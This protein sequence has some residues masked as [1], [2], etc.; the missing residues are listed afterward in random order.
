MNKEL[1]GQRVAGVVMLGAILALWGCGEIAGS[2]AEMPPEVSEAQ[3]AS[4]WVTPEFQVHGHKS[5]QG[6]AQPEGLALTVEE[7][8]LVAT[9]EGHEDEVLAYAGPFELDLDLG[10]NK[11]TWRVEPIE[12]DATG[13]YRVEV[14]VRGAEER[15]ERFLLGGETQPTLNDD[16]WGQRHSSDESDG[17]PLPLPADQNALMVQPEPGEDTSGELPM[18]SLASDIVVEPGE[19]LLSIDVEFETWA[20]LVFPAIFEGQGFQKVGEAEVVEQTVTLGD[21]A[22]ERERFVE[23]SMATVDEM[24]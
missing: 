13:A 6:E 23:E 3:Q 14:D 8:R 16:A 10:K 11:T 2:E 1:R 12:V 9:E 21:G 20:A 24:P 19:Q 22:R 7:I 15:D 17:N 18:V 5:L 4:S